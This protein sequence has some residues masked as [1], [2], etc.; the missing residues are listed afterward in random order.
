MQRIGSGTPVP[1][2][3][4]IESVDQILQAGW[5]PLE[6]INEILDLS[7]IESGKLPLSPECISLNEVPNDRDA[8]TEPQAHKIGIRVSFSGCDEST[9][10]RRSGGPKTACC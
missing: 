3:G 5:Y 1:T 6:L 7:L 4:Q 9:T 10:S 8:M 2:A